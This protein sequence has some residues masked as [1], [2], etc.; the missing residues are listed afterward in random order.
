[1]FGSESFISLLLIFAVNIS[2]FK[3]FPNLHGAIAS[4]G[5]E[6]AP[7]G[8]N[9]LKNGGSAVDAAISVLLCE[10]VTGKRKL[11]KFKLNIY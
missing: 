10:G 6:C 4:N 3:I 8:M 1:M 9:V 5:L 7:I 2:A 11:Q